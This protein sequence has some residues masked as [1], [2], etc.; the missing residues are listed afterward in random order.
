MGCMDTQE[1]V[2][3]TSLEELDEVLGRLA[4]IDGRVRGVRAKYDKKIA[5][6]RTE[7]DAE[8]KDDL[9]MAAILDAQVME[10]MPAQA[11]SLFAGG[12]TAIRPHAVLKTSDGRPSIG[13]QDGQD[14]KS[15]IKLIKKAYKGVADTY[16]RT[17]ESINKQ[18]L[19]ALP[20]EKLAKIGLKVVKTKTYA[21]ELKQEAADPA[22]APA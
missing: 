13:F 21:Y 18:T 12:K 2:G 7:M 6:L 14:E 10:Y 16:V 15:V 20:A 1:A 8:L 3:I 11:D 4:V 19:I 5:T 17:V 22:G 9:A